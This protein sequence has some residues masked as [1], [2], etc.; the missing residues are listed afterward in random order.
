ML[1]KVGILKGLGMA[2]FLLGPKGAIIATALEAIGTAAAVGG[3]AGML[4]GGGEK[5]ET[6]VQGFSGGGQVEQVQQQR[7]N[8][9]N[10]FSWMSGQAQEA[11]DQADRGEGNFDTSTPVGAMLERRRKLQKQCKCFRDLIKGH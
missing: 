10:P 6:D 2:K 11:I 4:G 3:L 8:F 7:F 9:L 5:P 1:K